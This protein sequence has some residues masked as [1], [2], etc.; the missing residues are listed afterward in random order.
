M[1]KQTIAPVCTV[2]AFIFL[3]TLFTA[4]TKSDN[5]KPS[6]S[7]TEIA[8][9]A[10][11]SA[12]NQA[13]AVYN[14]VTNNVM[15][16]NSQIGLGTGIGIFVA[17]SNNVEPWAEGWEHCF[18]VT[19]SPETIGVFPKT[20]TIDFGDGCT[21]RDGHIRKGKII[22]VYTGPMFVSGSKATTTLDGFYFDSL[23]VEGTHT[24]TNNSTV[25]GH[26]FNAVIE[27][28]KITAPSANYIVWARTRT[29][30]QTDGNGTAYFPL[31]DI[32]SITGNSNGTFYYS[33]NN[34]QWTGSITQPLIHKLICPWVVSGQIE[35]KGE[36][37]TS[38]LDFGDGACDR[39]ATLTINGKNFEII[40]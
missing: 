20:V 32:Y 7:A 25:E 40:W 37:V 29:W 35:I 30:T 4:C 11:A 3:I 34:Y 15:G 33:G 5:N 19:I 12:D 26:V 16:V 22:T 2:A 24:L 10:S 1:K 23:H 27:D 28:G 14:D 36:N 8:L 17:G 18:T 31:D 9:N 6:E 38:V 39:K 21:G 13:D